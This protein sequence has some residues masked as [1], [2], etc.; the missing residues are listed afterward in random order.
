MWFILP[1]VLL[2]VILGG[3]ILFWR[4]RHV[5]NSVRLWVIRS[6][7]QQFE[8]RVELSA[9]HVTGFAQRGVSGEDLAIHFDRRTEV[10][11]I[12]VDKFTLSHGHPR[13]CNDRRCHLS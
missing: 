6:L 7:S 11:L 3:G 5:E 9:V 13:T 8:G 10:P 2:A 12:H 4:V 1:T